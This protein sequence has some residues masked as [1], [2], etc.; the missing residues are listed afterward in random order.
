MKRH[1]ALFL[2]A[3]VPAG[4]L[5]AANGDVILDV[6]VFQGFRGAAPAGEPS[7]SPLVV[8]PPDPGWSS[9]IEKQRS[10]IAET[11]GLDG[12]TIIGKARI[13][14]RSGSAESVEFPREGAP[15]LVVQLK[16]VRSAANRVSL[17][18]SLRERQAAAPELAA[19]SVSGELGKTF[20]VGG[21]SANGPLLVSVMPRDPAAV[22]RA[23][24]TEKEIHRVGG[25]VKPPVLVRKVE[26]KYPG[27]L[28]ADKKSGI[29]AL[30]AT[31][32]DHGFVV[33]PVVIRHSEPEFDAA[34]L[35]A[36]RQWQYSPATLEGKPVAI[37]LT[38]TVS[39]NLK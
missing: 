3:L 37:Y 17:E 15:P 7:A 36:V 20:I 26:P 11:L 8:L 32:D 9:E 22:P 14:V 19:F 4:A 18:I 35:E 31:I 29:V 28:R 38:I 10:Q 12:A 21:K 34:A 6:N 16:P 30:Q 5:A 13:L 24:G 39:F 1:L 33:N 27:K 2:L 23:A 25:E